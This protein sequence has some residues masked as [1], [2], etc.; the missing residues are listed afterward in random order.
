MCGR[1]DKVFAF[2]E[3]SHAL[4]LACKPADL[5]AVKPNLHCCKATTN[6]E[7]ATHKHKEKAP[8]MGAFSLWSN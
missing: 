4:R 8:E 3:N 2:G 5:R 6:L 1:G 7:N